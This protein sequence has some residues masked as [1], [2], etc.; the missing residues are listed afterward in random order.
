[1]VIFK[2]ASGYT[3]EQ[4]LMASIAWL[5]YQE[6]MTQD[7]IA[8][9]LS[10][11]RAKVIRML[12]EAKSN[13]IVRITV[14]YG[15][16]DCLEAEQTLKQRY[17]LL[18]A[19]VIPNIDGQSRYELIGQA[20]GSYLDNLLK[21]GD[22]LAVGWGRTVDAAL[23]ALSPRR[24]KNHTVVSLYGGLAAGH[25]LN[26]Y[27]TTARFARVLDAQ[28]Y[29]VTAPM[30]VSDQSVRDL[31]LAEPSVQQVL[32]Q[33]ANA[34]VALISASDLGPDS[35]NLVYQVIDENL[36]DSL[37]AAGAV[38]D[39]CGIYLD[40]EGQPVDHPLTRRM[41]VPPLDAIRKIPKVILASGGQDKV[42]ILH[43]C[44]SQGLGNILV[45]DALTAQALLKI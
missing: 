8:S 27:D 23:P 10:M 42:A 2:M 44:L 31:I 30:F 4:Q 39:S 43:A 36:R 5:Y 15:F 17:G 9:R 19:R 3:N 25:H 33:A 37:L 11:T 34:D 12:N 13:G 18:D 7:A 21:S 28:S 41:I 1:M 32:T 16:A 40:A 6:G 26:P 24:G 45:T 29:Y 14:D 20:A 35:K 22:S 38:G